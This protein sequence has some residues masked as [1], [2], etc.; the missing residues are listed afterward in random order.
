MSVEKQ[1]KS[2]INKH[3]APGKP[4]ATRQ[5]LSLAKRGGLDQALHRLVKSGYLIRLARGVFCENRSDCKLPSVEEIVVLK[6]QVFG[7]TIAIHGLDALKA[8]KMRQTGNE[9]ITVASNGK[10]SSFMVLGLRVHLCGTTM[11]RVMAGDSK[12]GLAIRALAFLK[13]GAVSKD[14]V[15]KACKEFDWSERQELA[16]KFPPLMTGWMSDI[17]VHS[18]V[19]LCMAKLAS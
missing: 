3:V 5:L 14:T 17:V 11:N 13:K 16:K 12:A 19:T 7:K 10:S 2:F 1:I 9:E 15:R 18:G 4:F 8:L 6:A